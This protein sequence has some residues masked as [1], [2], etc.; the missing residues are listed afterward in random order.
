MEFYTFNAIT[1][2]DL[3]FAADWEQNFIPLVDKPWT[4]VKK[5]F[6]MKTKINPQD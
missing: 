2:C 5:P 1:S 3:G 6:K 4:A